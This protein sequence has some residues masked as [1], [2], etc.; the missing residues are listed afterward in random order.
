MRL[1]EDAG[2]HVHACTRAS[3]H[4]HT[5]ITSLTSMHTGKMYPHPAY[6]YKS[7]LSIFPNTGES[8]YLFLSCTRR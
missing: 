5:H 1:L 4:T 8:T 6:L 3:E 2:T 7:P